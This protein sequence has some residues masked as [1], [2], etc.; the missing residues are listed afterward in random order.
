MTEHSASNTASPRKSL[1]AIP[2]EEGAR[3]RVWAPFADG[4]AV[5]G[6]FN[7]WDDSAH[8]LAQEGQGIWRGEVAGARLGQEYLFVIFNGEQTLYRVDPYATHVTGSSGNAIITD[9]AYDWQVT[10][11]SLAPRNELVIYELHIGTFTNPEGDP[12]G[13]ATFISAMDKLPYLRDLGVNA[14]EVMPPVEFEGELSWG[15]NP[16]LPFAIEN[17]Y[18]G[19][20]TFKRFVDAAHQE[21]LAVFL[22]VVYNHFGPADLDLWRFDGWH[23]GRYGGIYFYNDP[24]AE[25]PWGHTRPDYGRPEV[26]RFICDNVRQWLEEYHVDGLRFDS[27]KYLRFHITDRMTPIPDAWRLLREVNAMV[28]D[29]CPGKLT[30]AEDLM[31]DP[32][33]TRTLEAGGAG[34]GAQWENGFAGRVRSALTAI[35]D[36][37]RDLGP[38]IAA[39]A[40]RIG[41]DAFHSVIYT[42]SHDEVANGKARLVEEI[43]PGKPHSWYAK[44]RSTLGAAL[45]MTSPG[46]PMLFQGQEFLEDRW[47][48]NTDPLDWNLREKFPGM[49]L[50]YRDLIRLRRN[51]SGVSQGLMGQ[52]AHVYHHNP[53]EKV[54]ALHRWGDA[55]PE[56]GVV[57]VFNFRNRTLVDYRVGLPQDG[58]WKLRFDSHAAAYDPEYTG[59]VSADAGAEAGSADGMPFHGFVSLAPYSAVIYS[60]GGD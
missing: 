41:N 52:H 48:Q 22:D 18:G 25:T 59:Q 7:D 32:A 1:G 8:P 28:N 47:F 40:D 36:D 43:W 58:L 33:I 51:L 10:D 54:L 21:G 39:L 35:E 2:L 30:I 50:L 60:Q 37:G 11:F 29:C 44:K 12:H 5:I 23:E 24:R 16:A 56:D 57:A 17:E 26:R 34:F 19:P 20:R 15:Y 42:E 38:V 49:V 6:Q 4:V 55:D 31:G 9:P 27:T 46:I 14:V 45:L 53:A 13:A 3:F